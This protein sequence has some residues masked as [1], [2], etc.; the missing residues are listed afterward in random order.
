MKCIDEIDLNNKKII[1]RLDLNVPIKDGIILDDTK[2]RA[3]IPTINYLLDQNC[4]LLIL[5]HLGKIK[6]EED[7]VG[8]SLKIVCDKMKE[9]INK[10]IY[11]IDNVLSDEVPTILDNHDIVMLENTRYADIPEKRESGC[12]LTLA[13]FWSKAGEF[14]VNDAF[15]TS[16]RKHASNYG[17]ST[18]L[19]SAYGL[20]FKK[21]VEGLK[22][23]VTN[24]PKRPFIVIMGG[25]KVD[26]K[27]ELIDSI[28]KKCDYLLLGG[29][30]ANTFNKVK[31]NN[32]GSSL[33]SES[34]EENVSTLIGKYSNKIILPIDANVLKE[35]EVLSKDINN[36]ES[37]EIIYDIGNKTIELYKEYIDE[38]KTI[39]INGTVGYYEDK[40][41]A[42]GTVKLLE[43]VS[44]ASGI[45]I[46]GGGDAVSS[47][48]NL[49]FSDKFNFISTGGGATLEYIAKEKIECFE[50]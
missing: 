29:G 5:S 21:E 2:I 37:D 1:L 45:K 25:A 31:G 48:N 27:I 17:I 22:P 41:F 15:G 49:G 50:D 30:I 16:H 12:D 9:L 28:L 6:T 39:F 4:K 11:F 26:D 13:E 10:D 7:K 23:I 3:S 42:N 43:L 46:A 24:E 35:N 14:F 38:A 8:K 40:R 32:I 34:Q 19:P 18:F 44:N 33:Y 36:I 47:V 20:L